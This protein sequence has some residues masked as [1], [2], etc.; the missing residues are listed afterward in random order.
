MAFDKLDDT[1]RTP[2][3]E[4]CAKAERLIITPVPS[5]RTATPEI[6]EKF[7]DES[8][9]L[10]HSPEIK[11]ATSA[12]EALKASLIF[13]EKPVVVVGSFYLVGLVLQIL[14]NEYKSKMD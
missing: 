9:A 11:H 14:E 12:E 13:P 3:K 6:L 2:L 7:L 1:I 5:P 10:E 8:G 4:L